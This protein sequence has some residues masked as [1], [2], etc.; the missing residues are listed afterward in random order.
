MD[1]DDMTKQKQALRLCGNRR[2]CQH[3]Y[4]E[5]ELVKYPFTHRK[6]VETV[7][8]FHTYTYIYSNPFLL[9]FALFPLV[10]HRLVKA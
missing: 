2:T 8:H 1:I 4:S 7:A 6:W 5:D 10:L 3:N 9:P